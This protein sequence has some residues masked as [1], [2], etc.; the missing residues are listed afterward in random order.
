MRMIRPMV[1]AMEIMPIEI[2]PYDEEYLNIFWEEIS[3][4]SDCELVYINLEEKT[5]DT[6]TYMLQVKT[7]LQ[8]YLD[9]FIRAFRLKRY[10]VNK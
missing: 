2:D 9:L 10:F 7:V 3:R 4:M 6:Q 5:P 1:R 8:Y